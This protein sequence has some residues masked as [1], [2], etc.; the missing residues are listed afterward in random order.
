MGAGRGGAGGGLGGEN[1]IFFLV[2]D[3]ILFHSWSPKVLFSL[4]TWIRRV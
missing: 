1:M 2:F 3:Q 4:F